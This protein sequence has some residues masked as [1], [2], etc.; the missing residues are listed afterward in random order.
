MAFIE[1]MHRN[2]SNITYLLGPVQWYI[3]FRYLNPLVLHIYAAYHLRHGAVIQ[4][5]KGYSLIFRIDAHAIGYCCLIPSK[6]ILCKIG[7]NSLLYQNLSLA[8]IYVTSVLIGSAKLT[9]LYLYILTP[10]SILRLRVTI[11]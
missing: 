5:R 10:L 7:I 4:L 2:K 1:P 8:G 11:L 9:I 3:Y 6:I